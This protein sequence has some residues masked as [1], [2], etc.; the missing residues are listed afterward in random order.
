MSRIGEYVRGTQ[1]CC[2]TGFGYEWNGWQQ[3]VPG[4]NGSD[5]WITRGPIAAMQ[6]A[7][8]RRLMHQTLIVA[9][10]LVSEAFDGAW[11]D[12]LELMFRAVFRSGGEHASVNLQK[13]PHSTRQLGLG[14]YDRC[15]HSLPSSKHSYQSNTK[16][17][18]WD[19][20]HECASTL[21]LLLTTR[22]MPKLMVLPS[23]HQT[24]FLA[25]AP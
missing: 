25:T 8:R 21:D 12:S 5:L 2:S 10:S 23:A 15:P 7:S 13:A 19:S 14:L 4:V 1:A 24:Y 22:H 17:S 18:S 3:N 16:P 20:I 6:K 11:L 9:A